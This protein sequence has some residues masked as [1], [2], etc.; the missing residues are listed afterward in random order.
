MT[1]H[2]SPAP[3]QDALADDLDVFEEFEVG[4]G[5]EEVTAQGRQPPVPAAEEGGDDL[6]AFEEPETTER[7]AER[8]SKAAGAGV[9]STPATAA[10]TLADDLAELAP[11][12]PVN[13]VAVVGKTQTTVGELIQTRVGQVIDLGRAPGET[14]DLI[15]NGKLIAR[16]ELVEM[17]GKMGVRIIKMVR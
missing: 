15:A 5:P 17:D 13:L 3:E 16:G 9:V 10:R 8:V 6:L 2:K 14:V 11:D 1:P 12:I 7:A 4:G